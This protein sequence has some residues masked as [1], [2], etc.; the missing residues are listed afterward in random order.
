MANNRNVRLTALFAA[1]AGI[2]ALAIGVFLYGEQAARLQAGITRYRAAIEAL[3]AR[4]TA[5]DELEQEKTRLETLIAARTRGMY[6]P[7][8]T[9]AY[10]FGIAVRAALREHGIDIS[11]YRTVTADGGTF[12]EFA[13]AGTAEAFAAFFRRVALQDRRW[14]VPQVELSGRGNGELSCTMRIGYEEDTSGGE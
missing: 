7:G 13:A 4:I 10:R 2:C 3:E 14:I 9:D 6:R 1:T 11:A 5:S 8:E 12:L